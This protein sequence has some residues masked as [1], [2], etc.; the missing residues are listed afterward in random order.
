MVRTFEVV[1][2]LGVMLWIVK[3][4]MVWGLECGTEGEEY[5]YISLLP[6]HKKKC[7]CFLIWTPHGETVYCLRSWRHHPESCTRY[8]QA[9][10]KARTYNNSLQDN[11][12]HHTAIT[13]LWRGSIG[14]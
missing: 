5:I 11:S 4:V 7:Y 13:V 10:R 14:T 12:D 9:S 1:R 8:Y 6:G 3:A 2:C